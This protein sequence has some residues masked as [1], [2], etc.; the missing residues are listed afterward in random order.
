MLETCKFILI[1][2]IIPLRDVKIID[3][4]HRLLKTATMLSGGPT[5]VQM[6]RRTWGPSQYNKQ[7]LLANCLFLL[8][9]LL[10]IIFQFLKIMDTLQKKSGLWSLDFSQ[11]LK[12]QEMPFQRP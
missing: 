7:L 12:M 5:G 3:I 8:M 10:S 9:V 1:N 6:V 11:N 2:D 4:L